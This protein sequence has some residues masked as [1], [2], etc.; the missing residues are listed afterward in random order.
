MRTS[1]QTVQ[2]FIDV[3]EAS[4]DISAVSG[5]QLGVQCALDAFM[6]SIDAMYCSLFRMSNQFNE[7]IP[8]AAVIGEIK[9]VGMRAFADLF[10]IKDRMTSACRERVKHMLES[11]Y[12]DC[13]KS[14]D[15]PVAYYENASE[16]MD[17]A[18]KHINRQSE[19][20]KAYFGG[21]SNENI[22]ND[23]IPF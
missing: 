20:N 1:S 21:E 6:D 11:M 8:D 23:D 17:A 18:M 5:M 14:K 9:D 10:K 4:N 22:G 16:Y 3:V 13:Q 2:D 7:K 19:Y 15:D 12:E